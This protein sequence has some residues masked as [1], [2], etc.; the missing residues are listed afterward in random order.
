MKKLPIFLG[1]IFWLICG[2]NAHA[3]N[4]LRSE[5]DLWTLTYESTDPSQAHLSA[6][7]FARQIGNL[8]K[9]NFPSK[10]VSPKA[11]LYWYHKN[12]TD[13]YRITWSCRIIPASEKDADYYFDRRGLLVKVPSPP[14]SE[15]LHNLLVRFGKY[16]ELAKLKN[17]LGGQI[18]PTFV[19]ESLSGSKNEGYW[20]LWEAFSVAPAPK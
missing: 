10:V 14:S 13:W 7:D 1:I 5:G 16:A 18:P 3:T 9:Q 20:D 15:E 8:L 19:S 17:S 12:G 11:T 6:N 4:N 2:A